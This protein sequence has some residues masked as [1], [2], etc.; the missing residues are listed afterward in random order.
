VGTWRLAMTDMVGD[1][2]A[3]LVVVRKI[4]KQE[5]IKG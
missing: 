3:K 5:E 1:R 4:N 2:A